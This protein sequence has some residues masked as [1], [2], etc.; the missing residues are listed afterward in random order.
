MINNDN[1]DLPF[2]INSKNLTKLLIGNTVDTKHD[3]RSLLLIKL[4]NCL[5][6]MDFMTLFPPR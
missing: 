3:T 2:L 6:S 4:L 1:G 5:K